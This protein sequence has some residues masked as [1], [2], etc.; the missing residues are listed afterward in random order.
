VTCPARSNRLT[1]VVDC[2]GNIEG[3]K[4]TT[5][6]SD[7][8]DRPP[9][10]VKMPR[11]PVFRVAKRA[12]VPWLL[13]LGMAPKRL[14]KG[15]LV[16]AMVVICLR[17]RVKT[18][19]LWL[20]TPNFEPA[21][22][23]ETVRVLSENHFGYVPCPPGHLGHRMRAGRRSH[24]TKRS[25]SRN[26]RACRHASSRSMLKHRDLW[27][28]Q[29]FGR[30][31]HAGRHRPPEPWEPQEPLSGL[32][33]CTGVVLTHDLQIPLERVIKPADDG[34]DG[35]PFDRHNVGRYGAILLPD[36]RWDHIEPFLP[37]PLLRSDGGRP[38]VSDCACVL[39]G[40]FSCCA[41]EDSVPRYAVLFRDVEFLVEAPF[42]RQVPTFRD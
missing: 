24:S 17:R 10:P 29:A 41:D 27:S 35:L 42:S 31:R 3:R 22:R 11:S 36:A 38:R 15:P 39:T 23:F 40:N 7:R 12:T 19:R 25:S 26:E 9:R 18:P 16:S 28:D 32:S 33:P 1:A 37:V 6:V 14:V 34:I 30:V 20:P 8:S 21:F 2:R 13:I 4:G 5:R